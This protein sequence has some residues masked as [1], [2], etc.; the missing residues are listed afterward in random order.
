MKNIFLTLCALS[1]YSHVLAQGHSILSYINAGISSEN[2]IYSAY[3]N[4]TTI[5]SAQPG[6]GYTFT[7]AIAA[8]LQGS[9]N[10]YNTSA[11]LSTEDNITIHDWT[12]GAFLRYTWHTRSFIFAYAQ[13]NVAYAGGNAVEKGLGTQGTYNGMQADIYPAI[14]ASLKNIAFTFSVGG[15][16]YYYHHWGSNTAGISDYNTVR[17]TLGRQFQF[18]LL[19]YFPLKKHKAS[20]GE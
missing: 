11:G 14:G 10:Q 4:K 16:G 5:F 8:G 3:G 9:Y 12:A 17:L 1:I 7:P 6:I 18:G 2:S 20:A 15:L 19:K 13:A